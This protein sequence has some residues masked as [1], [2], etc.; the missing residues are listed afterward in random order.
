M[1]TERATGVDDW[2]L[3]NWSFLPDGRRIAFRN[4]VESLVIISLDTLDTYIL[5]RDDILVLS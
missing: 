1:K 2:F 5:M 4:M 3:D